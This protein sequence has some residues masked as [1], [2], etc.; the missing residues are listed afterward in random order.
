MK[1]RSFIALSVSAVSVP[2]AGCLGNGDDTEVDVDPSEVLDHARDEFESVE[3]LTTE[4]DMQATISIESEQEDIDLSMEADLETTTVHDLSEEEYKM[5]GDGEV[6]A[7]GQ[8][9]SFT[10]EQ[11]FL[12]DTVY[13]NDPVGG[14]ESHDNA[15][16]GIGGDIKLLAVTDPSLITGH[17]VVERDG[18]HVVSAS[19]EE[20]R[21]HDFFTAGIQ[22]DPFEEVEFRDYSK[23]FSVD[24]V[25]YAI[26]PGSDT[27]EWIAYELTME[28][29]AEDMEELGLEPP[30]DDVLFEMEIE[31]EISFIEF[32]DEVD[33]DLPDQVGDRV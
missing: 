1:R 25:E 8:S 3:Y 32:D 20:G 11:Y 15:E 16:F 21:N 10:V 29:D 5:T 19:I 18:I 30:T 17:S 7:A 26:E 12:D 4:E 23:H 2:L 24:E 6:E 14:W 27:L 22:T 13:I 28:L 9:E 33:I 31:A